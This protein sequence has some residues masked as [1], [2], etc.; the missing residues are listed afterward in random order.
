MPIRHILSLFIMV[1]FTF[2]LMW[3]G[4]A[5][6]FETGSLNLY[7]ILTTAKP[8]FFPGKFLI[9][10]IQYPVI[11]ASFLTTNL[12]ILSYLYGFFYCFSP[13]LFF[14]LIYKNVKHPYLFFILATGILFSIS[15]SRITSEK[16]LALCLFWY[17]LSYEYKKDR[18]PYIGW[19]LATISAIFH[20]ISGPMLGLWGIIELIL[21]R[22]KTLLKKTLYCL[23]PA[24]ISFIYSFLPSSIKWHNILNVTIFFDDLKDGYLPVITGTILATLFFIL[25]WFLL[26]PQKY[27]KYIKY[28]LILMILTVASA[29]E[30]IWEFKYFIPLFFLPLCFVFIYVKKTSIPTVS[31]QFYRNLPLLGLGFLFIIFLLIGRERISWSRVNDILEKRN[32]K[33]IDHYELK[34]IYVSKYG[35]DLPYEDFLQTRLIFEDGNNMIKRMV[36]IGEMKCPYILEQGN[37]KL[38]LERTKQEVPP[39]YKF[40]YNTNFFNF[41]EF[42]EYE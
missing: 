9:S 36:Y 7:M 12:I 5:S 30:M 3:V 42:F 18:N 6:L 39:I 25:A 10:I 22:P 15:F 17:F 1:F 31:T 34:Q 13:F 29:M 14:F 4:K 24:L 26:N 21:S 11:L 37:L 8:F 33:C 40:K 20:P 35:H 19:V 16:T 32:T 23:S 41:D 2:F 38:L 28:I 27:H